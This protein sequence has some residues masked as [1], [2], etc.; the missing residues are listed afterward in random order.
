MPQQHP[1][2]IVALDVLRGFALLGMF[3]V[4]FH[5]RSSESGQIDEVIRTAIWRLVESKSH[6]TFAFLFGAGFA[7]Q[8]RLAERRGQALAG[9]YLR[10][11]AVLA[12]FGFVAH[13]C[14]GFN[15]L[16]GYAAWGVALLLMRR[17]STPALLGTAALCA[18]SVSLYQIGSG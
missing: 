13:A 17:W 10:R 1:E 2:R 14:F 12:M 16:L 5:V 15:V 4:H 8:F 18:L 3:I 11:L 6:G 9:T 7:I